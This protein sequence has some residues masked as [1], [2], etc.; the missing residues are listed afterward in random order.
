MDQPELKISAG[1][2]CLRC[3]RLQKDCVWIPSARTGRPRK[4]Q[5]PNVREQSND[6]IGS[7]QSESSI[8]PVERKVLLPAVPSPS[9]SGASAS[10]S[11]QVQSSL[12]PL[13]AISTLNNHPPPFVSP[14]ETEPIPSSSRHYE[15]SL[16]YHSPSQFSAQANL[17]SQQGSLDG[18]MDAGALDEA[19]YSMW[20]EDFSY[21]WAHSGH[22]HQ[23]SELHPEDLQVETSASPLSNVGSLPSTGESAGTFNL[24]SSVYS[25]P[26]TSSPNVTYAGINVRTS[27][28]PSAREQFDQ[29]CTFLGPASSSFPSQ[30]TL[31]DSTIPLHRDVV[32]LG[33]ETHLSRSLQ[34]G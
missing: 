4:L 9:P 19:L 10:T 18:T 30:E 34:E 21:N 15:E 25:E 6:R 1:I 5:L 3:A 12:P 33:H 27:G 32:N 28:S 22:H 24:A 13:P 8:S 7:G 29:L 17:L 23:P 31:Q 16:S 20:P 26:S 2:P 14:R 11:N